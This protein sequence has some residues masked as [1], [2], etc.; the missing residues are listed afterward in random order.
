M[1][2]N[3]WLAYKN[4]SKYNAIW[5]IVVCESWPEME[6]HGGLPFGD[7]VLFYEYINSG[8]AS[9][10]FGNC[11]APGAIPKGKKEWVV[12]T[13]PDGMNFRKALRALDP[14]S[15]RRFDC[16]QRI[17]MRRSGRIASG[18]GVTGACYQSE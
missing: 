5:L 6:H 7:G 4:V 18:S 9:S 11:Q 12:V 2:L 17:K 14:L 13:A 15:D 16:L 1:T 10:V 3:E 8:D